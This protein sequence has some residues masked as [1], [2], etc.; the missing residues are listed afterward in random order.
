MTRIRIPIK[1]LVTTADL[2]IFDMKKDRPKFSLKN[3]RDMIP[4]VQFLKT[5]NDGT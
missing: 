4:P 1:E 5:F 3:S 2:S